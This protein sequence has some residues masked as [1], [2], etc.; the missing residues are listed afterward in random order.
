MI[1]LWV[2]FAMMSFGGLYFVVSFLPAYATTITHSLVLFIPL[3]ALLIYLAIGTPSLPSQPQAERLKADNLPPYALAAKIENH[4]SAYPDNPQSWSLLAYLYLTFGDYHQSAESFR[5]AEA[6]LPNHYDNAQG[7][8]QS[9]L[10]GNQGLMTSESLALF[11]KANRLKPNQPQ[12]L[13]FLALAAIQDKQTPK[14]RQYLLKA[15]HLAQK[16]IKLRQ[17]IEKELE[18]LDK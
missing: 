5:R 4:L 14:A 15:R 2:I 10:G 9:L 13:Y 18:S 6:L 8:A 1:W 7:L 12:T 3:S 16:N 17:I 11:E